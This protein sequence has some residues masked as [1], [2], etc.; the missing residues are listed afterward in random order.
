M[1]VQGEENVNA[2]EGAGKEGDKVIESGD[3]DKFASKEEVAALMESVKAQGMKGDEIF[4]LITSPEFMGRSTPPPAPP[5]PEE[6]GLTTEEVDEL[7]PSQVVGHILKEVGKMM[8]KNNV[9]QKENLENVAASIKQMVDIAADKDAFAQIAQVKEDYGSEEFEKYRPSMAKIVA[10]TPNIT[11]ERAFLIA[12]GEADPIKKKA[13]RT[14]TP[15]EKPG[16]SAEFTDTNL[17][18]AAAAE[19][20]YVKA[21]GA[22][23]KPI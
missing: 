16:Q 6:K 21:F 14:G 10:E 8:E 22:D 4:R 17:T 18:P 7:K 3:K 2:L 23:E 12:K 20:A 5:K 15:T 11:A 9:M 1:V 19:K 13:V